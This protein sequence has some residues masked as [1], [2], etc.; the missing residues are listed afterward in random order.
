MRQFCFFVLAFLALAAFSRFG[1]DAQQDP[2]VVIVEEPVACAIPMPDDWQWTDLERWIWNDLCELN[3]GEVNLQWYDTADEPLECRPDKIDGPVP[4]NRQISG[5][6]I[7]AILTTPALLARS[8]RDRFTIRCAQ[9][10]DTLNLSYLDI[11]PALFILDSHF[12]KSIHLWET[13]FARS[14]SLVKSFVEGGIEADRLKIGGSL[15]LWSG[16]F[17]GAADFRGASVA[18]NFDALGATFEKVLNLERTH[19]RGSMLLGRSAMFQ[20]DVV[21]RSASVGSV[22]SATTSTFEGVFDGNRLEVNETLFLRDGAQFTG[23]VSLLN[24]RIGSDVDASGSTFHARLNADSARIGG[25]LM[26]RNGAVFSGK[27][28]LRN[29]SIQNQISAIGSRFEDTFNGD[30]MKL[31]GSLFLRGGSVFQKGITLTASDIGSHLQFG[32][33]RFDGKI[34][35]T[36]AKVGVELLLSSPGDSHGAPTWGNDAELILRNVST[37]VLQAEMHGWKRKDGSWLKTDLTGLRYDRFGGLNADSWVQS[38]NMGDADAETLIA[39]I[40]EAQPDHG[41]RYDPQPYEQLAAALT[42]AGA[43][44]AAKAVRFARY[45]HRRTVEGTPPWDRFKL[46]L[47]AWVIGHGVYPFYLLAWFGA[48][49]FLGVVVAH[50]SASQELKGFWQKF[51]Y[52]LEN[53]LPLVELKEAHKAI[54][55]NDGLAEWVFH[56]QKVAGFVLATILV[57]ALTLLGS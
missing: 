48:L 28:V 49:V 21:L 26:L 10:T 39:W 44:N 7:R 53:A 20:G 42:A 34:N 19:V 30:A 38:A 5:E 18:V 41:K 52:S 43:E 4:E 32:A 54:E 36:G 40:E 56:A 27:V 1:A 45:E 8:P 47:S 33:S 55:H 9:I 13:R 23:E 6:F 12:Q 25:S 15:F 46:G 3:S 22:L 35:M 29:A 24:A 37:P 31:G 16:H 50:R 57:G 2:P 11:K 14:F 51:W 17:K